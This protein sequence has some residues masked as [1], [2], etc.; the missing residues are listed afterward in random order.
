M[1]LLNC[2]AR[3]RRPLSPDNPTERRTERAAELF[4]TCQITCY[5][6][7]TTLL[8]DELRGETQ[9]ML[10]NIQNWEKRERGELGNAR[11][12]TFQ[13]LKFSGGLGAARQKPLSVSPSVSWD[14][15][16]DM[17]FQKSSSFFAWNVIS[18]KSGFVEDK[19]FIQIVKRD[20]KWVRN[21]LAVNGGR[22]R[23]WAASR[24]TIGRYRP[25]S[26]PGLV[27]RD[28]W[29]FRKTEKLTLQSPLLPL[30]H[31]KKRPFFYRN[32]IVGAA[33]GS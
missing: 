7:G 8:A 1:S 31:H 25:F 3:Q 9:S 24:R 15:H 30:K 19:Y 29:L 28:T 16:L 10:M 17:H 12:E 13:A 26:W 18:G 14:I 33:G 22:V 20:N 6:W 27:A 5:E 21:A 32:F 23:G 4:V 11:G 2:P